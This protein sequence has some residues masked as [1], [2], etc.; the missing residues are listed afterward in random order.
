LHFLSR[1]DLAAEED[2]VECARVDRLDF[3][4][5]FRSG[6]AAARR[7]ERE[8]ARRRL[9][10]ARRLDADM[11]WSWEIRR[12]LDRINGARAT[13]ERRPEAEAVAELDAEEKQSEGVR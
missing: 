7:G 3:E 12:E 10:R 4:A 8:L 13:P 5:H 9:E 6:V 1:D 11:K 2:F